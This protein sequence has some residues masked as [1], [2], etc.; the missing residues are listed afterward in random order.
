MSQA[1]HEPLAHL[2]LRAPISAASDDAAAD[3]AT[4]TGDASG[5]AGV[6]MAALPYRPSLILR[7]ESD[8]A[9]FL[10]GCRGALGFDLPVAPN[11]GAMSDGI[12]AL[13]LG[14]SEWLVLGRGC[15]KR[16]AE[17]LAGCRHALV[18]N[19]DGQQVI[20]LSGPRGGDVLAKLCPL[21]LA[22]GALGPG[23][24]TRSVL[25]GIAMTLWIRPGGVYH[26]HVGRSFADYAWRILADAGLE[27]G[28][29]AVAMVDVVAM[30]D[31][32]PVVD[33]E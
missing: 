26:I 14:P 27:Y 19:G 2:A 11:H 28:M 32:D 6:T 31:A 15:G 29:A 20:A 24:C 7:G 23:R 10:Q 25:A 5:V 16:L 13:W 3:D 18:T 4:V 9:A 21:D 17:T 12:A 30:A 1:R 22:G 8:D 33:V